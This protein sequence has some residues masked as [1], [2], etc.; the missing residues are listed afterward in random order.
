MHALPG[1]AQLEALVF[2]EQAQG[3]VG[4]GEV[5]A[6]L[7]ELLQL[8]SQGER[9]REREGGKDN[10]EHTGATAG[11]TATALQTLLPVLRCIYYDLLALTNDAPPPFRDSV[12]RYVNPALSLGERKLVRMLDLWYVY[13][14]I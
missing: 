11:V 8:H 4:R 5:G 14:C 7:A 3:H 2:P 10:E 13:I 9:E 1:N 12:G 6:L